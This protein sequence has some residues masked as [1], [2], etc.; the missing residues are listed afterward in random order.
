MASEIENEYTNPNL[1]TSAIPARVVPNDIATQQGIA[2]AIATIVHRGD[3]DFAGAS[4]IDHAARVAE[5][6]DPESEP[7]RYCAAWLHDVLEVGNLSERDLL[8]AG[9][10][11]E[12]VNI[13]S[14]L[15]RSGSLD[16]DSWLQE[17]AGHPDARA[18]KLRAVADNAAAWR[19]R[20][21]D[22]VTRAEVEATCS[23]ARSHLAESEV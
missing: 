7:I 20:R 22:T 10:S 8:D 23:R 11:P 6:F 18:V 3:V 4:S 12:I 16:E 19:L 5:S 17:I 15:T 2:V 13:V 1:Q 14:L 9:V 21:L